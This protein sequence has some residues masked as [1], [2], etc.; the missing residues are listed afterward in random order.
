MGVTRSLAVDGEGWR[1]GSTNRIR[2]PREGAID[3]STVLIAAG[4]VLAAT[5]V[6][7]GG[8]P[9]AS[10]RHIPKASGPITIM[11]EA[12]PLTIFPAKP[13]SVQPR[14]RHEAVSPA[15]LVVPPGQCYD[16]V[17]TLHAIVLGSTKTTDDSLF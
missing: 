16:F 14:V 15:R 2:E 3:G 12:Y 7:T 11:P 8:G 6:A 9:D 10:K 17:R 4:S 1:V 13:D 5:M